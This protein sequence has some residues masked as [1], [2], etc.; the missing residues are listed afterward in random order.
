MKVLVLLLSL[1]ATPALAQQQTPDPA[2]LQRAISAIQAQRNAALDQA[3][4]MQV[5]AQRLADENAGL[6]SA[7]EAMRK[8]QAKAEPK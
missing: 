1:L 3:A 5:E 2:T 6:K 8:A 7:L 4:S